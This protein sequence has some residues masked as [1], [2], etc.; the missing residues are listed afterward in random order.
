LKWKGRQKHIKIRPLTL[1][2]EGRGKKLF[3]ENPR[4]K[5]GR[6]G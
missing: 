3:I 4:R 1:I 6:L 5:E 2:G